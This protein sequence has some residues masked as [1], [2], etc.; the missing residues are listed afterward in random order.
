MKIIGFD[1]E[2]GFTNAVLFKSIISGAAK[3]QFKSLSGDDSSTSN[4]HSTL[5]DTSYLRGRYTDRQANIRKFPLDQNTLPEDFIKIPT[6][7]DVGI[8]TEFCAPVHG[9]SELPE[10][11][12]KSEELPLR[13]QNQ[14]IQHDA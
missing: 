5:K 6:I 4:L 12:G 11:P 2:S 14:T 3:I 10:G 7:K 8:C 9:V 13:P 1:D